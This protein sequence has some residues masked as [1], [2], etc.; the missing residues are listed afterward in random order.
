MLPKLFPIGNFFIPTYGLLVA[1]GVFLALTLSKRLADREGMDG[2]KIFDM[3]VSIVILGFIGAKLLLIV[4]DPAFLTSWGNAWLLLRSGGV[5]YGGILFGV[6]AAVYYLKKYKLPFWKTSDCLGAGIP[7][8][9]F[10]GRLGCFA[11][12]CCWGKA[13]DLP[14][15]VTFTRPDAHEL[16]GVPLH[17]PLQPTQLYEALFL[18]VLFVLLY[19]FHPRKKFDGQVFLTYV[20]CYAFFRFWMEFLRGDPRGTVLGSLS[21]SQAIAAG[22]F[23]AALAF[24]I[25][26]YG[27]L[28]H[29]TA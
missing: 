25:R 15:A 26:G 23:V 5:F 22:A 20:M 21:T 27:R 14:W 4:T 28:H 19:R 17:V 13:C 7:L 2:E 12:G 11:A 18:A 6:G 3:G 24:I 16:T 9:H 8:A 10:F 29:A 1:C